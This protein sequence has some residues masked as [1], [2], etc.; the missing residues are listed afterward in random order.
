MS[1]R[2][3]FRWATTSARLLIGAL[4]AVGIV[5]GVVT[6]VTIPWP[7]LAREPVAIVAEPAPAATTL[8]CTGGLLV[9]GRDATDAGGL[10][11]AAP[12]AVTVG[13]LPGS[14]DPES[15]RL[16]APDVGGGDGPSAFTVSPQDGARTDASAAGS[17]TVA[18]EDLS[19]FAASACRPALSESWLVSGS[20][21]VGAA[22]FV[23]L[24]NPGTSAS[25]VQLT[26]YGASGPVVPPGGSD[27]VV[28]PGAQRVVPLSG[29]ALGESSPVIRVN[30]EGAPVQAFVQSSLTRVLE[31]GGVDQAGAVAGLDEI[32]TIVGLSVT[33]G[34]ADTTASGE[35]S[36]VVRVLSPTSAAQATITVRRVGD[37]TPAIDPQTVPLEAGLPT[38]VGL[39]S[40]PVGQYV[41][42]VVAEAPV[43]A[44]VW[45]ATGFGA[46]SDFG[47]YLPSPAVTVPSLV[48]VPQGPAAVLTLVNA[49]EVQ[50]RIAVSGSGGGEIVTL[51]LAP[52]ASES[53]RVASGQSYVVDGGGAR[54]LGAVSMTA[55]NALAG[56]PVWPAD[57]AAPPITIYP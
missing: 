6:A 19:G 57:A 49:D 32:V 51:D 36:T 31:P 56:F 55:T 18:D 29:I 50:A 2:R 4:V 3:I 45:Q 22:D 44:G 5:V 46:D 41:V 35:A 42:D 9:Q 21:S 14:A 16:A 33:A 20:A 25:T 39:E 8:V 53:V 48:S 37:D 11:Q 28:P 13:V 54:V 23:V 26:L 52:G 38:E 17:S 24:A 10:E 34:A 27:I 40:L 12:Q 7:T 30:A 43:V 15:A 47:W 1:D